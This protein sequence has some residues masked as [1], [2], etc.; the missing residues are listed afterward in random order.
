ME[1]IV[2]LLIFTCLKFFAQDQFIFWAEFSAKDYILF[3]QKE[4]LSTAMTKGEDYFSEYACEIDYTLNDLDYLQKDDFNAVDDTMPKA[5]KLR[6]LNTHK[7]K[8][9]DCFTDNVDINV[10]DILN[11][12]FL[13]AKSQTYIKILPLRFEVEFKD[14]G[15]IIYY[16]RKEK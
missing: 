8:L 1:R 7:D 16:L 15:A 4:N 13:Q 10:K 14:K 11:T 6:F 2:C 5:L 3:H 12:E 9:I